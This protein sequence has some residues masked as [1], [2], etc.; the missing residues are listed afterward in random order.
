M[1]I[2]V[3]R[4]NTYRQAQKK[5]KK[6]TYLNKT[7]TVTESAFLPLA[8]DR[9]GNGLHRSREKSVAMISG[10]KINS[11]KRKWNT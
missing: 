11:T 5:K 3:S 9:N 8:S 1:R 2:G 6:K 4:T 7:I 10:K